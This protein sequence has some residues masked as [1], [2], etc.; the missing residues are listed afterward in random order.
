[1]KFSVD[2]FT[3]TFTLFIL[4]Y[5]F[6]FTFTGGL[7]VIPATVNAIVHFIMYSYYGLAAMGPRVRKYL[8]WKKYLTQLQMVRKETERIN[9]NQYI[10]MLTQLFIKGT[11]IFRQT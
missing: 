11:D 8:W 3:F 9:L 4:F 6:L 10:Y 2:I 5:S 7:Q 1:M